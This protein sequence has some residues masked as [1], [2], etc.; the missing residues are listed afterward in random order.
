MLKNT[1]KLI[2]S[3]VISLCIVL[4]FQFVFN[5]FFKSDNE[6]IYVLTKDI[7]KGERI[8]NEDLKSITVSSNVDMKD[9][10]D[11]DYTNKVA[12]ENL[13]KG[14]VLSKDNITDKE[15]LDET[16]E[17]YEYVSIEIKSISQ[18][19]AYQLK[20]GDNINV[21]FTSKD[22]ISESSSQGIVKNTK[23]IK[24]LEKKK[25]IGLYDSSG[26]EVIDNDVY[27]AIVL[28]VTSEEAV[29]IS[30]IKEE[31]NFNISLVK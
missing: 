14:Q 17:K 25:I 15:E 23:T 19:M 27:N 30:N 7:Y 5:S 1:K 24:I 3:F 10:F 22:I 13:S 28:R 2:I 21:Y 11:I 12:K 20:K 6:T 8:T 29:N 31:G 9:S 26:N 4:L 18:A 16:D